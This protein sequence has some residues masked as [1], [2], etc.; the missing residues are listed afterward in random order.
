MGTPINHCGKENI[1]HKFIVDQQETIVKMLKSDFLYWSVS[2]RLLDNGIITLN[3]HYSIIKKIYANYDL[4]EKSGGCHTYFC[5]RL[6]RLIERKA[7]NTSNVKVRGW[8]IRHLVLNA[9]TFNNTN[10]TPLKD[11]FQRW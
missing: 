8:I 4:M 1:E 11:L 10:Q 5:Y 9:H 6:W 3:E 7:L 2:F